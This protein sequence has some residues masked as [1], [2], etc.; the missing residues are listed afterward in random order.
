MVAYGRQEGL[1]IFPYAERIRHVLELLQGLVGTYPW[2]HSSPGSRL[3]VLR[4][5]LGKFRKVS[6]AL[7]FLVY[8]VYL[9]PCLFLRLLV[10][11]LHET[12]EDMRWLYQFLSAEARKHALVVCSALILHSILGD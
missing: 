8:R 5:S 7:Q 1:G 6:S 11:R 3:R 10:G 9:C 2:K 12:Q 4:A